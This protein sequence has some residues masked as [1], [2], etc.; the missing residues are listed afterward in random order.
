MAKKVT[1]WKANDGTLHD[2]EAEAIIKDAEGELNDKLSALAA[3]FGEKHENEHDIDEEEIAD[4][5]F[6]FLRDEMKAL[7]ALFDESSDKTRQKM[8]RL[9]RR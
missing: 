8:S 5:I 3:R 6:K 1:M 9:P 4:I 7:K 2:T